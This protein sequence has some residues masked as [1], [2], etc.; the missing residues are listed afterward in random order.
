MILSSLLTKSGVFMAVSVPREG[1]EFFKTNT[2]KNEGVRA[3]WPSLA[4]QTRRP[5][6]ESI[7]TQY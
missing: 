3:C 1:R 6:I 2:K 7:A 5:A 4:R